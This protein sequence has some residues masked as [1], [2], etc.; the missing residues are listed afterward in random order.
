AMV[1]VPAPAPRAGR[2][3]APDG[4]PVANAEL[5]VESWSLTLEWEHVER[6][7]VVTARTDHDGRWEVPGRTRLV[8]VSRLVGP[9][10]HNA[11]EHTFR[12][13]GYPH[14]QA[15]FGPPHPPG[16]ASADPHA[17]RVDWNGVPPPSV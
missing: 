5:T 16:P 7:N 10:L 11:D 13:P 12:A 6:V 4:K 9:T 15:Q 1:P 14:L 17:L 2:L 8:F 3:T